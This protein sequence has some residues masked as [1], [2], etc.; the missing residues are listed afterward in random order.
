M[1][2]VRRR[3]LRRVMMRNNKMLESHPNY[4]CH[5]EEEDGK[6]SGSW[7][8]SGLPLSRSISSLDLEGI[9]KKQ[10]KISLIV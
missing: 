2:R 3:R 9:L 4:A 10:Q 6:N 7:L 5:Y 1:G 8:W